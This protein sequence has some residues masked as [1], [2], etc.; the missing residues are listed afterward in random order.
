M[1]APQLTRGPHG[2]AKGLSPVDVPELDGVIPVLRHCPYPHAKGEDILHALEGGVV[3]HLF[4]ST[5]YA[6]ANVVLAL[7]R[8]QINYK[9]VVA[10]N[11]C[12]INSLFM[13]DMNICAQKMKLDLEKDHD[14][15]TFSLEN[16][17]TMRI[18]TSMEEE[19]NSGGFDTLFIHDFDK[20]RRDLSGRGLRLMLERPSSK[21]FGMWLQED[22][23]FL[24]RVRERDRENTNYP[25]F[26]YRTLGISDITENLRKTTSI[27]LLQKAI[28]PDGHFF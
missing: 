5:T 21:V 14:T 6:M 4:E 9:C 26:V 19:F 20:I 7:M 24:A 11:F 28:N 15:N 12:R 18:I 1:A 27:M 17:S 16:G 2:T 3:Y 25:R 23:R 13:D 22:H 10:T 8:D